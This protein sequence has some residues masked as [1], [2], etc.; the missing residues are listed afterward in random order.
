MK[1]KK[2]ASKKK[3]WSSDLK[4]MLTV[5]EIIKWQ[6]WSGAI[7]RN[8]RIKCIAIVKAWRQK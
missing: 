1:N 5:Y 2:N 4:K 6:T 3:K 7:R 8:N